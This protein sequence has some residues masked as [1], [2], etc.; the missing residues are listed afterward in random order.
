MKAKLALVLVMLC[1]VLTTLVMTPSEVL[2]SC[3][4]DECGCS[5]LCD[6]CDAD[7]NPPACYSSCRPNVIRCSIGCCG[8]GGGV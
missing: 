2:A 4:G 7:I 6:G 5:S 3:S 1:L 8:G